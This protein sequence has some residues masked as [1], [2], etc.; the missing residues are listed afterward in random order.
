MGSAGF[1]GL[2]I[3]GEAM[4]RNLIRKGH[5]VVVWNRSEGKTA[6]LASEGA[7]VAAS[8]ADVVRRSA[9]VITMLSDPD[10]VRR[11]YEGAEGIATVPLAGK[12]CIDMSTVSP[13]CSRATAAAVS[14]AGGVFLEA[15]VLGSRKPAEAGTLTIL[16]GGDEAL[17]RTMEP[18]L[19][20]MGSKVVHVGATG[21]AAHMKL[22]VNQMMGAILC[23]FGEAALTG[24]AAGIPAGKII[25]VVTESAAAAPVV[26][27]KAA[28]MLGARAFETH[29]P[30]KHA[31]KD[32]KLAVLA[33]DAMGVPTPVTA[34]VQ[35]LFATAR[36][37]GFGDH[38]FS[39]VLRG[40]TSR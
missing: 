6:S 32:M 9:V 35:Q 10:A 38:D 1:I 15:P 3:M 37:R 12:A 22:I 8:P 30:L 34:A 4:C 11:V 25:E 7:S 36:E 23:V 29:F 39:A 5:R 27:M 16:T 24:L 14:S 33:G 40:L 2:G 21:A 18:L 26:G 19:L 31:L 17:S 20:A 28:D 13:D